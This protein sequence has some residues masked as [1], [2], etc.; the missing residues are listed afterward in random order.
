MILKHILNKKKAEIIFSYIHF[1]KEEEENVYKS[2]ILNETILYFH[3]F[4]KKIFLWNM[5]IQDMCL[6]TSFCYSKW[7]PNVA[8]VAIFQQLW[9]DNTDIK[10]LEKKPSLNLYT[11]NQ[12]REEKNYFHVQNIYNNNSKISFFFISFKMTFSFF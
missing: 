10:A 2:N 4:K 11:K 8:K 9:K 3:I 7:G 12:H 5:H 1:R 6:R